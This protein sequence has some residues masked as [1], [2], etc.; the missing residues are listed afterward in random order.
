[1][2]SFKWL[3]GK[4]SNGDTKKQSHDHPMTVEFPSPVEHPSPSIQ[5]DAHESRMIKS[6][7][8]SPI[9]SSDD[10]EEKLAQPMHNAITHVDGND[11]SQRRISEGDST[12]TTFIN[13]TSESKDMEQGDFA[14]QYGPN[15]TVT[16]RL[17]GR[18]TIITSNSLYN[19]DNSQS[20]RS[21]AGKRKVVTTFS[22]RPA[23][24][25]SINYVAMSQ[26]RNVG[27]GVNNIVNNNSER[28]EAVEDGF[29][30]KAAF[31]KEHKGEFESGTCCCLHV[32]LCFKEGMLRAVFVPVTM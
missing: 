10:E 14:D 28:E 2:K 4:L 19:V 13:N 1:M 20:N 9:Q 16:H 24:T 31:E 25:G 5:Y 32:S 17:G 29:D 6:R 26:T 11:E 7:H 8:L 30:V 15:S 3:E 18:P 22:R 12:Q 27:G 21:G 23:S